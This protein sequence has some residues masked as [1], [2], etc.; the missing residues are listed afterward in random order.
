MCAAKSL[1]GEPTVAINQFNQFLELKPINFTKLFRNCLFWDMRLNFQRFN[2]H[3]RRPFVDW[4]FSSIWCGGKSTECGRRFFLFNY[5][6]SKPNQ[7][8]ENENSHD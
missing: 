8:S 6:V 5:F 3:Y 7:Q 2:E 1:Y 4:F